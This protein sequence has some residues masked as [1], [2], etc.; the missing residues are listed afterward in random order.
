[1]STVM[2]AKAIIDQVPHLDGVYPN[3]LPDAAA[4]DTTSTVVLLTEAQG[5]T[6]DEY[7]GD[8]ATRFTRT[9]A[10]NIFY[11]LSKT[12]DASAVER[13][14]FDAFEGAGWGETYS[15][16]HTYDPT[17]GQYTKV[18]QFTNQKER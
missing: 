8:K 1:M 14:V 2:E 3:R 4:D 18:F 6:P 13:A 10:I 9:V 17:T 7:G 5:D 12:D 15:A 11:G 16:P